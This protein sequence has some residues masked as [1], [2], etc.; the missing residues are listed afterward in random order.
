MV[1]LFW[2]DCLENCQFIQYL[3]HLAYIGLLISAAAEYSGKLITGKGFLANFKPTG[4]LYAKRFNDEVLPELAN[5][6]V[7]LEESFNKIVFT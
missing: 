5:F 6:N 2:F 4:K 1:P 3:F 7:H